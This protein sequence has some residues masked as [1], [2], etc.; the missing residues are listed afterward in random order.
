MFRSYN[1]SS[2]NW[3]ECVQKSRSLIGKT[4]PLSL[5][6]ALLEE[7]LAFEIS[8]NL[9]H[10]SASIEDAEREVNIFFAKDEIINYSKAT[11]SWVVE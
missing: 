2:S 8:R 10:G 4:N 6:Q 9:I 5:S 11:D 7:I 3:S 1:S